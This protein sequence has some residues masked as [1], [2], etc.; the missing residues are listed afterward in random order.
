MLVKQYP[1]FI[2]ATAHD[3]LPVLS[4]DV[5][6]QII[7]DSLRFLVNAQRV[8]VTAFVLMDTHFHL[9]GQVLGAHK[10]EDVQRDFLRFTSQQILKRLRNEKPEV[11]PKLLVNT[12]DRKY[13]VWQR[14]SLSIELRSTKVFLQ[15]LEY[16]HD[17]PVKAG[18]CTLPEDYRYSSAG[19]Y[20]LNI[21]DWD[22]LT[23]Y[24]D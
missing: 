22:F 17:N 19:F 3:W 5:D 18:L 8:K 24:E 10:R 6:K 7:L 21:N 1:E 23:H 20:E 16:I 11:L 15:K 9:I 12:K 14:N 2:T 13:Q 4:C